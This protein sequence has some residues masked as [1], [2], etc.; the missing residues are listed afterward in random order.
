MEGTK[1]SH[2]HF[3]AFID[4][5]EKNN[6]LQGNL[7]IWHKGNIIHNS[8]YGS[9][10]IEMNVPHDDRKRFKIASLTKAFTA[11]LVFC[12]H[13]K[14]LLN[15][16]DS[17]KKYLPLLEKYKSVTLYHCLTC[18]S[19]I[20]DFASKSDYWDKNMRIPQDI[21]NVIEE[22]YQD[23]LNFTPGTAYE[24]SSTGYL[25]ITKII[26]SVTKLSYDEALKKYILIP[27]E[28]KDTGCMNNVDVVPNLVDSY[29]FWVE[30]IQAAKT[31]MSFPTGAAGMYS[32]T[33][34]LSKWGRA[35]I[36]KRLIPEALYQIYETAYKASY[37]CGW[38]VTTIEQKE[39]I[40]HQGDLDGFATSIKICREE[41]I[42][43][44][45]LSNQEIIPVTNITK[46]AVAHLLGNRFLITPLK[47]V[48]ISKEILLKLTNS[49][50]YY[51]STHSIHKE[52]EVALEG[53]QLFLYCF[54]RYDIQYKFRL[55]SFLDE[56]E[57][58]V[59]KAEKIDER[60][61]FMPNENPTYITFNDE[62]FSLEQL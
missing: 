34:D 6:Y 35:I 46:R 1:L 16:Y 42:V 11:M 20:P 25:I 31:D 45:F 60:I 2:E 41:E 44:V 24:Y 40:Q 49:Y 17:V 7:L 26:E 55:N 22:I 3:H 30:D 61:I 23:E 36:D 59:L 54:K 8:S 62:K 37:A 48:S 27:L 10:N 18:S 21:S 52:L 47:K 32:T 43:V 57:N 56:D 5:Y 58:V 4:Y 13:D 12:L 28:L 33:N 38:D 19:G 15:I 53:E 39:V 29:G 9:A 14:G 51:D 50:H